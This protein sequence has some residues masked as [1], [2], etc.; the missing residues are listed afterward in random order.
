MKY[1][2][3][4]DNA[5]ESIQ[6][7]AAMAAEH[8]DDKTPGATMLALIVTAYAQ[9]IAEFRAGDFLTLDEA[10]ECTSAD[11]EII[12]QGLREQAMKLPKTSCQT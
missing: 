12:H 3:I 5:V 4:A 9:T 10:L 6:R 8:L 2:E 7:I 1:E 11:L